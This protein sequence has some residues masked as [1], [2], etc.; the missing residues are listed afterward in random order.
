MGMK[1]MAL[2]SSLWLAG[3]S[4]FGING[5]EEPHF[6]VVENVGAIAIRQYSERVAAETTVRG[7]EQRTR[8]IGFR[9]IAGYIF[10]GNQARAKI[11]MTAP[12]AQ[13]TVG[14]GHAGGQ[15]IPMTAPVSQARATDGDWVVRFFMPAGSS[16]ASLPKPD[17]AL[18]RLV[19]V[20]AETYAVLRF[21]RHAD[22]GGGGARGQETPG[23]L[24]RRPV[25]R[26]RAAGRVV[27]RSSLDPAAAA[28]Q[29]SRRA[30]HARERLVAAHVADDVDQAHRRDRHQE[31]ADCNHKKENPE[32][33]FARRL[34]F[35]LLAARF[36]IH[37]VEGH[38][39]SLL[40]RAGRW[41]PSQTVCSDA[42][43]IAEFGAQ[44]R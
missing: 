35:R 13:S 15:T 14:G 41:Q 42:I 17:N 5:V 19:A 43:T 27:L 10:G 23:G 21:F 33:F 4:V 32:S 37:S 6:E 29:R 44:Q 16:L 26:G 7:S 39:R 8:D 30:R 28:S 18:V 20:P 25:V 38:G 34:T 22:T 40:F 11:A 2:F 36:E 9:R 31:K 24:A 3:C 1:W 12:V